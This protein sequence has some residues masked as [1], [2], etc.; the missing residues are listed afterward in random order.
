MMK[1]PSCFGSESAAVATSQPNRLRGGTG[2][3]GKRL[4]AILAVLLMS[5]AAVA[6]S[7]GSTTS[8][9]ASPSASSV[10]S[11]PSASSVAS[12]PS[13]SAS[14]DISGSITVLTNRTD[15]VDSVFTAQYVPAFNKIYPN[16]K[17]TFQALKDYEGDVKIRMNTTD[18]GD[19]LLIPNAIKPDQLASYFTPL[20]TVADLSK[21]YRLTTCL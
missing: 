17:V 18:Y 21:T 14:S 10:A 20:G 11:A 5:G 1:L 7:S 19:V 12:A 16:I 4:T 6:C 8:P 3:V 9:S 13:A 15:I 2:T